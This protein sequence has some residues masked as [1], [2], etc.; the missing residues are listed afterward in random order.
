MKLLALAL[1]TSA[2]LVAAADEKGGNGAGPSG[3]GPPTINTY[4]DPRYQ[5]NT[6]LSLPSSSSG[7]PA[8]GRFNPGRSQGT[9]NTPLPPYEQPPGYWDRV[10]PGGSRPVS[11]SGATSGTSG[12]SARPPQRPASDP[13]ASG[14]R[15]SAPSSS[16]V[17]GWNTY[18]TGS[19]SAKSSG[20]KKSGA[21]SRRAV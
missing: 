1:A 7:S 18:G 17:Q 12:S 9:P 5:P 6:G 21:K 11:T 16:T 10:P 20:S 2:A 14:G 19:Q 8:S 15:T 4:F 13:G 3:N